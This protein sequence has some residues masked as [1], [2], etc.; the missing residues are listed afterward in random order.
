MRDAFDGL[1]VVAALTSFDW[2]PATTGRAG[3]RPPTDTRVV[4]KPCIHVAVKTT[5]PEVDAIMAT[6][7]IIR[8]QVQSREKH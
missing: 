7:N 3:S 6:F 8:F 4:K 1:F 5:V 2:W